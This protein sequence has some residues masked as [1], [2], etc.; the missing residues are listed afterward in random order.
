MTVRT[1]FDIL[2][3]G[4]RAHHEYRYFHQISTS[5]AADFATTDFFGGYQ[6]QRPLEEVDNLGYARRDDEGTE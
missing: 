2:V 4:L 1:V 5:H 6:A 3:H